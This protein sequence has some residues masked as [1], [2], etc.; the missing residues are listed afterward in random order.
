MT[1]AL[2]TLGFIAAAWLSF[3]AVT[4]LAV[5][6]SWHAV[7]AWLRRLHPGRRARIALAAALAPSTVLTLLVLLCLSPG[8]AGLFGWHG[9]HC[10]LSRSYPRRSRSASPPALR[11]AR[12]G[13][14]PR[15][16]RP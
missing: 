7:S 1:S 2:A 6:L 5:T 8:L 4:S 3:A 11:G 16:W 15:W 10:L 12:S 14:P 9:D 13:S